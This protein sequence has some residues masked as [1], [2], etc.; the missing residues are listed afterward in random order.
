MTSG[1]VIMFRIG[2]SAGK[3]PKTDFVGYG[4]PSTT[5]RVLVSDDGLANLN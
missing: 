5:A 4:S 1:I 2:Q 3:E